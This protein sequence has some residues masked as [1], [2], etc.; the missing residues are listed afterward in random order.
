M[1]N[2][3]RIAGPRPAERPPRA[4]RLVPPVLL[5]PELTAVLGTIAVFA[6]FATTAGDAGFLSEVGTRN[7]LEVAAEV[8]IIAA[9]I[10]LLLIAGE[11]DLSVGSMM[12]SA[13]IVAS[14]AVVDGGMPLAAGLVLAF[15]VACVVGSINWFFVVKIGLPSF[16]VT[17]AM[18]YAVRGLTVAITRGATDQTQVPGITD[19]AQGDLLYS[20]FTGE[21]FGFSLSVVWWIAVT[22]LAAWVLDAT[23]FG[24]WIYATGGDEE[25]ARRAGVP[26]NRVKFTLFIATA[27]ASALVGVL[28]AFQVN[29]AEV[30]LG[31]L[32]E[33]EAVTATVIGGTLLTG[34]Y[35][36]PIGTLF[37]AL[38]F[39]MVSQGFFFTD[40]PDEW[41]QAFLG[42]MLLASVVVNT[43]T[44]R[45]AL[46]RRVT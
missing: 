4:S 46:R 34:G 1:Y 32:K 23:R 10:T 17:L 18:L 36:S 30:T 42:F 8:G 22:L 28:A 25:S 16:I 6:Y 40:I 33:F 13:A 7:Y 2:D 43:F 38:L 5:R 24:N 41:Y 20:L 12:G 31:T 39:G 44:R 29:S 19:E 15:G 3:A 37:G 27:L 26:V 21:I 11:F 14:Y 9:P 45:M 35:G